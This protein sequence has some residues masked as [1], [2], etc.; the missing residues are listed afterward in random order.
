M[1]GARVVGRLL[2]LALRVAGAALVWAE[3]GRDGCSVSGRAPGWALALARA[4]VPGRASGRASGRGAG[5]A[6][7][8]APARVVASERVPGRAPV[9][10]VRCAL[11]FAFGFALPMRASGRASGRV[12]G[13]AAGALRSGWRGWRCAL[14]AAGALPAARQ[15]LPAALRGAGAVALRGLLA[16][17]RPGPGWRLVWVGLRLGVA[18]V[19]WPGR[20]SVR[21]AG[22]SGIGKAKCWKMGGAA[23]A[24]PEKLART[25]AEFCR[26]DADAKD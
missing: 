14:A 12:S 10:A 6:W 2:R 20:D 17:W 15:T 25:V 9:C 7:G 11:G 22:A 5:R 16:L 4:C 26:A 13:R 24:G 3:R 8:R 19:G 21:R 23:R 1:E 18:A